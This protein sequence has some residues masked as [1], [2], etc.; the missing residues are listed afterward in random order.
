MQLQR[1]KPSI[2]LRDAK[3]SS[4]APSDQW[5]Q[6]FLLLLVR[7][8]LGHRLQ[9]KMFM[10]ID[11]APFIPALDPA[12]VCIMTAA[13]EIPGSEPPYLSGMQIPSHLFS[14]RPS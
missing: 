3:T 10:C 6:P 8:K 11:D 5:S 1:V 13:S 9:P 12:I 14:A 2:G 4:L 7:P